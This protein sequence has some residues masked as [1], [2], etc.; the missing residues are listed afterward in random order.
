MGETP[1]G[2]RCIACS[3]FSFSSPSGSSHVLPKCKKPTPVSYSLLPTP[4]SLWKINN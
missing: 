4:Y 1:A 2:R 3:L